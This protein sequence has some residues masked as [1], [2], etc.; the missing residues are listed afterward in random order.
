MTNIIHLNTIV[1][2][3][4]ACAQ[5]T[6]AGLSCNGDCS[7]LSN[8]RT[9]YRILWAKCMCKITGLEA[10]SAS[11][12][13]HRVAGKWKKT[14]VKEHWSQETARDNSYCRWIVSWVLPLGQEQRGHTAPW[15]PL[16][17]RE[18]PCVGLWGTFW[19]PQSSP[20]HDRPWEKFPVLSGE[21][22]LIARRPGTGDQKG[23]LW[24]WSDTCAW[25]RV[26]QILN[27][28]RKSCQFSQLSWSLLWF[29]K[30]LLQ[31]QNY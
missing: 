23:Q 3:E 24:P 19:H 18:G 30:M 28:L 22:A 6:T 26:L 16:Q 20:C 9:S 27:L 17:R 5:H 29:I 14:F 7:W 2:Q 13:P 8:S 12:T 21:H 1:H 11:G 15:V 31:E 25:H 10:H 4:Q